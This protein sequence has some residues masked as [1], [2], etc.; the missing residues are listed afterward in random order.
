VPYLIFQEITDI[1]ISEYISTAETFL[2]IFI[3]VEAT[4]PSYEVYLFVTKGCIFIIHVLI[5]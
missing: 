5:N 2:M 4:S 1:D 3:H